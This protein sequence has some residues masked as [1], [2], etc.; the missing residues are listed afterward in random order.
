MTSSCKFKFFALFP[1]P[2]HFLKSPL[3]HEQLTSSFESG[4]VLR[5]VL[6]PFSVI[7][8]EA[9]TEINLK[10]HFW[11]KIKMAGVS[12]KTFPPNR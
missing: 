12:L 10:F 7:K 9:G 2:Q 1:F 3:K 11:K 5:F 4:K 8:L 6:S